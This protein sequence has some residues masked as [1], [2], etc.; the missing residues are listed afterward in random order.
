MDLVRVRVY[1][2]NVGVYA[3]R[4][5]AFVWLCGSPIEKVQVIEDPMGSSPEPEVVE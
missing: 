1:T 4:N 5:P 2:P 3:F